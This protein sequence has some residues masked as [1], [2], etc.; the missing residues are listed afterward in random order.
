MKGEVA[1][2][3]AAYQQEFDALTR[4]QQMDQDVLDNE[5]RRRNEFSSKITQKQHE[6]ETTK[7]R[8]ERLTEQIE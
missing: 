6:L 4:E 2:Q 5:K 1:R 3:C 8:V 7:K